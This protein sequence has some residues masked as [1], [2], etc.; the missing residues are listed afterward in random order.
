MKKRILSLL[1]ACLLAIP[2]SGAEIWSEKKE[3][4]VTEGLRLIQDVQFSSDGWLRTHILEMDLTSDRLSLKTLYDS[5]GIRHL[6]SVLSMAEEAGVVAAINGDFFNWEGTPL[7]FTVSDGEIIS[8]PAHDP[9]LAV[10][11]EDE[12]GAVL[13]DYLDMH[14]TVTSPEGYEAEIIHINKYHSMESMVLYTSLWGKT[15]P[16]S[17]D[18]VSELVAVDGVVQEIRQDMDGVEVPENGFVLATSTKTSTFLVD[19]FAPGDEIV[20]S[21]TITPDPG[22]IRNAIGGGS[23][24]VENGKRATFTNV[25]SGS[26]PRTAVGVD[27]KGETLYLVAVDG[28]QAAT[29]G[30]TQTALADFMLSLGAYSA[31]NLDGGGSTTM[32]AR[33]GTTGK[34]RVVNTLS[35]G[36]LRSVATALGIRYVGETGKLATLEIGVDGGPVAEDGAAHLYLSAFDAFHNPVYIADKEISYTSHDGT[37]DGNVFYPAHSGICRVTVSCEG[38]RGFADIEVLPTPA[39]LAAEKPEDGVDILLLPGKPAEESCLDILTGAQ[40]EAMCEEGENVYTFGTY[41]SDFPLPVSRF[42]ATEIENSL[43]VTLSADGGIRARDA[44]QWQYCME[45]FAETEAENVFFLLSA[46]LSDFPDSEEAALF[47]RLITERLRM[48]GVE[49]FVVSPGA[50]MGMTEKNGIRYLTV[51]EVSH[52]SAASLFDD[53]VAMGGIRLTVSDGAVYWEAVP[54]WQEPMA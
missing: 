41:E 42:S 20:L 11:M 5:R 49:V 13:T 38:V 36:S 19:N 45:I 14:L 24:L 30:M 46:P 43:F 29:A 34:L 27:K 39:P 28:R 2:V 4:T 25:V 32:V 8:S 7:G 47:E 35:D 52:L 17:H 54:I 12:D 23:V 37:F 22:K 9:G 10:L 16:G 40:L 50:E 15:T 18:G 44:R 1:T 3:T 48:K 21:Y 53:S 6:S 51:A 33:E 31:I 26:H